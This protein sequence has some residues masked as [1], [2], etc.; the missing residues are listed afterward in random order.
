MI[1]INGRKVTDFLSN[2]GI[3]TFFIISFVIIL[4]FLLVVF[5]KTYTFVPRMIQNS[6]KYWWWHSSSL[7]QS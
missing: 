3:F 7:K 6:N 5:K 2:G 1:L 4:Q